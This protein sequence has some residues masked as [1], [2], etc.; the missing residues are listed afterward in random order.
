[1]IGIKIQKV[2]KENWDGM[3]N[4]TKYVT[5]SGWVTQEVYQGQVSTQTTSI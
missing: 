5:R 4:P 2:C 3:S 1:M